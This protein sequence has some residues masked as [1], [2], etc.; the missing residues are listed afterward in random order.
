MMNS[1]TK[2]LAVQ[3]GLAAFLLYLIKPNWLDNSL[4][5]LAVVVSTLLF[6]SMVV[7]GILIKTIKPALFPISRT[8]IVE[9][10]FGAGLLILVSIK[11]EEVFAV[12]SGITL[13]VL[14]FVFAIIFQRKKAVL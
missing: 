4:I 13:G 5:G 8:S 3:L 2:P 11:L 10:I 9:K 6:T 1:K 7:L 14:L 12:Y